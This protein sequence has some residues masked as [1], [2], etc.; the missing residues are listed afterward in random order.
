MIQIHLKVHVKHAGKFSYVTMYILRFKQC[1]L[2]G[3]DKNNLKYVVIL[4]FGVW[5]VFSFLKIG[6]PPIFSFGFP[7]Q[8]TS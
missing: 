3:T 7:E 8:L 5:E 4:V 2:P 1:R 6:K